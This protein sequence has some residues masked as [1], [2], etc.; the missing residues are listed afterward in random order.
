MPDGTTHA[1]PN[2]FAA[3]REIVAGQEAR[4]E[5]APKLGVRFS[6]MDPELPTVEPVE[7]VARRLER[8]H[9]ARE[10]FLAS[11]RGRFV[12]AVTSLGAL[13]YVE[14]DTLLAIYSRSLADEGAPID[15]R[16]IDAI[17]R[18]L[19]ILN[20]MSHSHAREAID[21]LADLMARPLARAA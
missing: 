5:A 17:G 2:F 20:G 9:E 1:R 3:A 11:P 10:A 15:A 6:G 18:A 4:R 19:R 14:A 16:A 13:G 12:K 8:Q 7:T 21:A